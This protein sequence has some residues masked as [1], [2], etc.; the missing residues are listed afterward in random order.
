MKKFNIYNNRPEPDSEEIAGKKDFNSVLNGAKTATIPLYKKPSF[1]FSAAASIIIVAGTIFYFSYHTKEKF[2]ESKF[3]NPPLQNLTIKTVSYSIDVATGGEIS[4]ND[5]SKI[6]VPANAFTDKNGNDIVGKVDITYRGFHDQTDLLLSGIPMDYD[7]GGTKYVFSSAGM[8]DINGYSNGNPVFIKEGKNLNVSIL[9]SYQD[10]R[11]NLYQ[12]DTINKK[13]I[14]MG[15]DKVADIKPENHLG[16]DNS[17][18]DVLSPHSSNEKNREELK[19]ESNQALGYSPIAQQKAPVKPL[20]PLLAQTGKLKIHLDVDPEEFPEL[21]VYKNTVFEIQENDA[22]E[23]SSDKITWTDAKLTESGTNGVY[24]LNLQSG[25]MNVNYHVRPVFEGKDL[26]AAQDEYK[27]KFAT[28]KAV[29][30]AYDKQKAQEMA[31]MEKARIENEKAMKKAYADAKKRD[32][33]TFENSNNRDK[34]GRVFSIA[35]FGI[36]NCDHAESFPGGAQIT[37][38]IY[39]TKNDKDLSISTVYLVQKNMNAIVPVRSIY[40]FNYDPRQKSML[41]VIS[42]E[43][44]VYVY[45]YGEFEKIPTNT[46]EFTFQLTE[47]E[48]K[49]ATIEEARKFLGI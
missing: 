9:S 7:S 36:W 37:N 16:N 19:T 10:S 27:K 30:E 38:A 18:D 21:S 29:K 28:Y 22:K 44:Q 1:L 3:I 20:E 4:T 41:V 25:S 8:V 31:D 33:L 42:N 6:I 13:W 23:A 14:C 24:I 26:A 5:G 34:V 40:S 45:P 35:H 48:K 47:P 49:L 15:K 39:K 2:A 43:G 11:Y 17:R 46:K 12:L 32:S